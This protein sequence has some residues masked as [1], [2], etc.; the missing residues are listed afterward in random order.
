[1]R[2]W[3]S[4]PTRNR[5]WRG[6]WRCRSTKR[7]SSWI[8]LRRRWARPSKFSCRG[9]NYWI[10]GRLWRRR[11]RGRSMRWWRRSR[12][13]NWANSTPIS[14]SKPYPNRPLRIS[15][16]IG[17]KPARC[18]L[19][20]ITTNSRG[21]IPQNRTSRA[22]PQPPQSNPPKPKKPKSK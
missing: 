20:A 3:L 21:S 10:R 14:Y 8:K 19:Q 2:I 4:A 15:R 5:T 9:R 11:S 22:I 7:R 18:Q 17:T 12:R 16:L 1:M 13:L 6:S